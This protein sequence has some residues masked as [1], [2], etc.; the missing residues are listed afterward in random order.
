[1]QPQTGL[2]GALQF[3][4]AARR[5]IHLAACSCKHMCM[6]VQ[7]NI[8][9][10]QRIYV[11]FLGG[12]CRSY[13]YVHACAAHGK[14]LSSE[15]DVQVGMQR[16]DSSSAGHAECRGHMVLVS[17]SSWQPGVCTCVGWYRRLTLCALR[18]ILQRHMLPIT[19]LL[20]ARCSAGTALVTVSCSCAG[21]ISGMNA[22]A[23]PSSQDSHA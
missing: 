7:L 20:S 14:V 3:I 17:E 19:S 2:Q 12:M 18:L 23:N 1:M 8:C 6:H 15:G 21:R 4:G 5:N 13:V 10:A 9:A 16:F 22:C 11:I